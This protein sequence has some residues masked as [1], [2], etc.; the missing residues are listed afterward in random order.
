[1]SPDSVITHTLLLT[2]ILMPPQC[3][4]LVNKRKRRKKSNTWKRR[5]KEGRRSFKKKCIVLYDSEHQAHGHSGRDS[6]SQGASSMIQGRA[7][8][9]RVSRFLTF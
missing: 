3:E 2:S 1:M 7:V 9:S 6:G 4:K 8:G 5:K